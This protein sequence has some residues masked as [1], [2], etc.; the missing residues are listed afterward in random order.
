MNRE[1]S[2]CPTCAETVEWY[3]DHLTPRNADYRCGNCF[4]GITEAQLD[5]LKEKHKEILAMHLTYLDALHAM[6][7]LK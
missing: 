4:Y 5:A 6:R 7:R 2:L 1:L 3:N